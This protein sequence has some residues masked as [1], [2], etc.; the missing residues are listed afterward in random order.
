MEEISVNDGKGFFDNLGLI[1]TLIND[2]NELPKDLMNGQN[3]RFCKRVVDMVQKLAN[4]KQGIQNDFRSLTE[5]I[6]ELTE[7]NDA[8]VMEH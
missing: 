2:C 8:D 5:Q 4:L 7:R 3:V 6:K 1:D